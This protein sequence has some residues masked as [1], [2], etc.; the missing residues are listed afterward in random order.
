MARQGEANL[1]IHKGETMSEEKSTET[2]SISCTLYPEGLQCWLCDTELGP[3]PLEKKYDFPH[4]DGYFCFSCYDMLCGLD[5]A[6]L[7]ND[8]GEIYVTGKVLNTSNPIWRRI[9]QRLKDNAGWRLTL[10]EVMAR[11]DDANAFLKYKRVKNNLRT[12]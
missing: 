11:R 7:L 12:I 1:Y 10:D 5:S 8:A 9:Q 2:M 6:G 4:F 3:P